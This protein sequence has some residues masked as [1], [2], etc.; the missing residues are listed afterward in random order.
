MR[1]SHSRRGSGCGDHRV[2]PGRRFVR[3]EAGGSPHTNHSVR[4]LSEDWSRPLSF[5]SL[6]DA[7]EEVK[8]TEQANTQR[9]R[10]GDQQCVPGLRVLFPVLAELALL[11]ESALLTAPSYWCQELEGLV[12][13]VGTSEVD[14]ALKVS[15]SFC[16]LCCS[17]LLV[18][19]LLRCGEASRHGSRTP[20]PAQG[21]LHVFPRVDLGQVPK[22][23][24]RGSL[25]GAKLDRTPKQHI[26]KNS[27]TSP[28]EIPE[29]GN[30]PARVMQACQS[31]TA[32]TNKGSW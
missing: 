6:A 32:H 17:L 31:R 3:S 30:N 24:I 4:V 18:L 15:V 12:E 5:P 14:D 20:V 21:H 22:R 13:Y 9:S 28:K 19:V 1:I 26:C 23:E 7:R 25:F 8:G 2:L 27:A 11:R 10:E 16:H 29:N